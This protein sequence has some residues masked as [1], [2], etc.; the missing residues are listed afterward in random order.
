CRDPGALRVRVSWPTLHHAPHPDELP[1]TPLLSATTAAT[2]PGAGEKAAMPHADGPPKVL[3]SRIILAG[4]SGASETSK[5]SRGCRSPTPSALTNASL[6]VQQLKNPTGLSCASR[7]RYASF[8]RREKK[9]AA[10]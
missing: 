1:R 7:A 2:K 3:S 6:R 8:S 10:S 5:E 9:R 4:S